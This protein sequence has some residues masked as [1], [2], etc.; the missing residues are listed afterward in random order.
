MIP[1]VRRL[2]VLSVALRLLAGCRRP[3]SPVALNSSS[4]LAG[5]INPVFVS[6]GDLEH[7]DSGD[8]DRTTANLTSRGVQRTLKMAT[9]LQ[10]SVL[11]NKHVSGPITSELVQQKEKH[12]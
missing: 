3:A 10:I 7:S 4:L 8:V 9:F 11:G 6:S 12:T 5:S 1:S 2:L